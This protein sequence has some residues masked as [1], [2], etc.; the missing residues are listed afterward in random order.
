MTTEKAVDED[1]KTTS[2]PAPAKSV[3]HELRTP[4][5]QIIGYSELLSE[6]VTSEGHSQYVSDLEKIGIAARDLLKKIDALPL[7]GLAAWGSPAATKTP[8]V[9]SGEYVAPA[10]T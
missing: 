5:N 6:E 1:P 8:E 10:G 9:K 3:R 4:I 2:P 7:D